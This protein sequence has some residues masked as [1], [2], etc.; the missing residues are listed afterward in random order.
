MKRRGSMLQ[1]KFCFPEFK[2]T[3]TYVVHG[4][5][6]NYW[7]SNYTVGRELVSQLVHALGEITAELENYL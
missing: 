5:F 1:I 3:F 7:N 4:L 6:L 2:I